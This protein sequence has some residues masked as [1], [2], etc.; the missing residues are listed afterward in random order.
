MATTIRDVAKRAGVSIATVS[1]VINN[2]DTHNEETRDKVNEAIKSLNYKPNVSAR[3]LQKNTVSKVI[4]IVVPDLG[5]PF[6]TDVI[7]GVSSVAQ[8]EGYEI[9]V[10][11]TDEKVDKEV[12]VLDML[13][14]QNIAGLIITPES[15]DED[16][17]AESLYKMEN[18]GI[19]IVLVDRDVKFHDFDAVFL[20]NFKGAYDAVSALADEG[21]KRISIIAGPI[22]SKPGKDRFNGYRT[23]LENKNIEYNSELVKFGDFRWKSGYELAGQLLSMEE[24]PTAI[25]VSNNLMTLGC[26]SAI[27]EANLK[28]PD[29]ISL[30]GFD[31]V[32]VFKM[33]GLKISVVNRPTTQ[34]GEEAATILFQKMNLSQGKKPKARKRMILSLQLKLRGSEK[35]PSNLIK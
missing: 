21:H 3:A 18:A 35:F 30:I 22:S 11:D 23:A 34:M 13:R 25:F 2:T 20:D 5:N 4:A 10:C 17:N 31:D 24:R 27:N 8:S 12:K 1:R 6:F 29:D 19:P 7:K 33:L 28:I 16:H 9:F 15:H 32:D 26:I 14:F